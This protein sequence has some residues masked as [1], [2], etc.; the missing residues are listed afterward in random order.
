[1]AQV[2]RTIQT[3][4]PVHTAPVEPERVAQRREIATLGMWV[5]LSTEVLF[6]GALLLGYTVYR[7]LYPQVFAAASHH[8]NMTIGG[9]NTA[10]LLISSLM[11]ALAVR[12]AQLGERGALVRY[13]VLTMVLGLVFLGL[14]GV[15]YYGDYRDGIMPLFGLPFRYDG[16]SPDRARLFFYLY[17]ILTGLHSIHLIIGIIVVGIMTVMALRNHF[18]P[19]HYTPVELTGLYWHFVDI[20]WVFLLP[21]L[22]LVRL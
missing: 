13:L 7:L 22:Y 5:F 15:E 8:L 17:Y 3:T 12:A 6:F 4:A 2:Q 14:K 9:V 1:M 18:S 21:L 10:V 19:E 16:A 20:V 11:M